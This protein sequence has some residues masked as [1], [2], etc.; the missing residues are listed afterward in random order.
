[1]A[2]GHNAEYVV[3][4]ALEVVDTRTAT[5][6]VESTATQ[7]ASPG[8]QLPSFANTP[9]PKG[10]GKTFSDALTAQF[11][12]SAGNKLL[13]ASG[14]TELSQAIGMLGK[15]TFLGI[16]AFSGDPS[17]IAALAVDLASTAL[18][19]VR[20]NFTEQAMIQNEIDTARAQ[21]GLLDLSGV[22]VTK[23][24]FTGRY[25]YNRK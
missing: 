5:N 8:Q 7:S 12:V 25:Q 3:R 6:Q 19:E 23:H 20:K 13:N 10:K 17:A 1:M 9:T 14:N 2:E 24:F 16:R 18:A 21:A 22:K 15:Y 4:V 11:L